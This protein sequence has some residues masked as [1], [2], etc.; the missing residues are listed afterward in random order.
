MPLKKLLTAPDTEGGRSSE[1]YETRKGDM[2]IGGMVLLEFLQD[3][4]LSDAVLITAI[5]AFALQRLAFTLSRGIRKRGLES[6]ATHPP[7][8][9]SA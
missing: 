7:G 2:L 9:G 3:R 6:C 1:R 8:D 5:I 4:E